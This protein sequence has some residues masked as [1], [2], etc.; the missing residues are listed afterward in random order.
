M[1]LNIGTSCDRWSSIVHLAV[2]LVS[3][4]SNV[5]RRPASRRGPWSSLAHTIVRALNAGQRPIAAIEL[6][7]WMSGLRGAGGGLKC[8]FIGTALAALGGMQ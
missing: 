2:S 7:T 5:A 6:V 3:R 4:D 1:A 8:V